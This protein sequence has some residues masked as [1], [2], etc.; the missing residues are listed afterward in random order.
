MN[1]SFAVLLACLVIPAVAAPQY[2]MGFV[3]ADLSKVAPSHEVT[4]VPPAP[5]CL[6]ANDLLSVD[7]TDQM[8]PI[9]DQQ[10]QGSCMSWAVGYYHRTQLEYRE[11]GWDLN[12]PHH[13]FSAA[14]L[15]N[16]VNGGGD[17]GSGFDNNMPLVC[18]QGAASEALVPYDQYDCVSWPSE[19][20]YYEAAAYR[21][22]DWTWMRTRNESEL[23][24][25]K[26][27]LA[28]GS[29]IVIAINCYD[30]FMNI[31]RYNNM[32]CVADKSGTEPG[33]HGVCIVGYDDTLTTHDGRGAFR[34][35]NSWGTGW[36]DRGY[37]W[38][39]YQAVMDTDLSQRTVAYLTDTVGYQPTLFARVNLDH[40]TR[41]RVA[42][43]FLVGRANSPR[44]YKEFRT[45]RHSS[46]NQPFPAHNMVFDLTEAAPYIANREAD[47]VYLCCWDT[48]RDG[49]AGAVEHIGGK[50]LPWYNWYGSSATPQ[51]IADNGALTLVGAKLEQHD[52]DACAAQILAPQGI[53]EPGQSY[54]PVARVWNYGTSN[55]AIPV[56]LSFD[57]DWRDSA[58]APYLAPGE[59]AD[60]TFRSWTAPVTGISRVAC[61]TALGGDSYRPNDTVSSQVMVRYHDVEVTEILAPAA[62]V[63]S[64]VTVAPKVRCRNNGTQTETFILRFLIP[65][66]SYNRIA[67][68]SVPAGGEAQT[69]FPGWTPRLLGSHAMTCTLALAGDQ[70]A[71]NNRINGWVE[72]TAGSGVEEFTAGDVGFRLDAAMPNPFG[73]STTIR[74]SLDRPGRAILRICDVTGRVVLTRALDHSTTGSFVLDGRSL[75][76]GSYFVRLESAGRVAN[77]VITKR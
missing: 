48:R 57:A 3:Y 59:S 49:L 66:E 67:Q 68:L 35:V 15:Y 70:Q 28:N 53:V 24:N 1:R 63:D 17:N 40:P 45:W 38:M 30:N 31:S 18:E 22:S 7:L 32:Y 29:T 60:V 25:V 20:A 46:T 65:D 2:R 62:R 50:Y 11:R 71:G 36:G 74:Y 69:L 41:D 52:V 51:P 61:S 56:H 55:A 34:V 14:Y 77:T 4:M 27:V 6:A 43:Q 64:G 5:G 8:P 75:T 72:V 39:S 47:S 10:S 33:G 9:G 73:A 37:F 58:I 21:T 16:Q 13:R 54:Q 42:I 23:E 26:Q 76:S 19:A 44:W 12:D